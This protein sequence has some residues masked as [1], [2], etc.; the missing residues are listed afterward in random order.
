M[1]VSLTYVL[2]PQFSAYVRL[3]IFVHVIHFS[4]LFLLKFLAKY[5]SNRLEVF[6][7]KVFL[8]LPQNSQKRICTGVSFIIKLQASGM[9]LLK[10][11]LRC[12]CFPVSFAKI[13]RTPF[14][15]ENHQWLLLYIFQVEVLS[16][17]L[18]I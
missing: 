14:F 2:F 16:F 11:R 9:K 17:K 7:E 5:R 13:L 10:R 3:H 4:F 8:K 15:I 1:I 6:C 12:R 18:H